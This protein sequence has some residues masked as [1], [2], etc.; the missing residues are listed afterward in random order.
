MCYWTLESE[1]ANVMCLDN[2]LFGK[3]LSAGEGKVSTKTSD[4][5]HCEVSPTGHTMQ[6]RQSILNYSNQWCAYHHL[7]LLY[8]PTDT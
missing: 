4:H 2:Y 1:R 5:S 6:L 3:C 8:H 7:S